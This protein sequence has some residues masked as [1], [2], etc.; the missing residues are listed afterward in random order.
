MVA[1]M[2]N[3]ENKKTKTT[4][5]WDEVVEYVKDRREDAGLSRDIEE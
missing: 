3:P 1:D 2:I 4:H 5:S